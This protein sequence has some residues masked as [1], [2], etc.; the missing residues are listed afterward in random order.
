MSTKH[1]AANVIS[2]TKVVP[3]GNYTS[4]AASGVWTLDEQLDLVKGDNWPNAAN[5]APGQNEYTS[6]GNYTFVV[7][8]GYTSVSVVCIGAAGSGGNLSAPSY[9]TGGGGGGGE[10]RYKN[11][12]TVTPGNSYTVVVGRQYQNAAQGNGYDGGASTFNS[13]TCVANGGKGGNSFPNNG[14]GGDGGSGGTGDGGGNGGDGGT[15]TTSGYGAGGGGAGGYA[16]AGGDGGDTGNS[17]SDGAGGG[18]GGGGSS[19]GSGYANIRGAC[20][21]GTGLLGQGSNGSGGASGDDNSSNS[22]GGGGGSGGGSGNITSGG[23][24]GGGGQGGG[25]N[26][27]PAGGGVRIMWP[28]NTRTYPS[29]NTADV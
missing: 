9:A 19:G 28:G 18:A 24:Y 5:I 2:A 22:S 26:S 11:N 7:P 1:F 23:A 29:T 14:A 21:G 27:N 10:L 13:S 8:A 12:I 16:G 3:D 20:G 4:S 25:S 15:C 17:G 6:F